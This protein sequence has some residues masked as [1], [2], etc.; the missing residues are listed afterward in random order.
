[1][2]L[3]KGE[4]LLIVRGSRIQH[5]DHIAAATR[6]GGV[7]CKVSWLELGNAL[8]VVVSKESALVL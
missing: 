2:G 8:A 5:I 7:R 1:M 4:H 3:D 6:G